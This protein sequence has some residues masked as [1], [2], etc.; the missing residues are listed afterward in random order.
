MR[1]KDR[2]SILFVSLIL[3]IGFSFTASAERIVFENNWGDAGFNL[4]IQDGAGVEIVFSVPELM[5]TDQ[6]V[7]GQTMQHVTIPGIYLPNDAGAPNLPGTGRYIALPQGATAQFEI[8]ETRT[9]IYKNL[10]IIPAAPIPKE[11]DTAPPVYEKDPAIY[12]VD[13]Y[14]PESPVQISDESEMRGVDVVILGVRPFQYNPVQKELVVYTDI[15]VRVTF[16]GGNGHFGEDRLRSRYWEPIL[17]QHLLNYESLPEVNFNRVPTGTDEDNVEYLIIVPD[18]PEFIAW[19]DTIKNWRKQQG[20]IT[21][22]TNLNEIG[23]NNYTMIESY[24]N[25]AYENW[26]IPPV[27]VLLLSDY[28]FSADDYGIDSPIWN[29]YCFS[30][31]LYADTG[32][33]QL[34]DFAIARIAAQNDGQLSTMLGKMLDYERTPPTAPNFYDE[35]LMAGGWQTERWFILCTEVIYGYFDLIHNKDPVREYAIYSGTPGTLWSTNQNT[36]MITNYFGPG[37]Y[38]YIPQTPEHLTNWT[39][40]AAGINA[41]IN[42]GCFILQHRDHGYEEGWGEPAYNIGDLNGLYNEMLPFVF[43]TNCCTGM[44][45]EPTEVFAEAFHRM[46]HGCLGIIA[47][48]E[49]SYSFVNDTYQW[50]VYDAMWPDFDPG[51]GTDETGSE[52]LRTAFANASGKHYLQV[53]S[54]PSN[55]GNKAHTYALFHH[56]GDAFMTLY[57]EVPQNLSVAHPPV[58]FPSASTVTV[59]ADSGAIVALTVDNEIIGITEATG[60]PLPIAIEPQ[61]PNTTIMVTVTLQN[62][63]R[64]MEE[65]DVITEEANYVVYYGMTLNDAAGNNNEL[66]DLGEDVL[67]SIAV[68]NLGTATAYNIEATITSEDPHVVI[69]DDVEIY[70]EIPSGGRVYTDD[71]YEVEATG[72]VPDLHEIEFTMTATNG[73]STWT[74]EFSII[75][76]APVVLYEDLL[77][78]DTIGG[79]GNNQLDPGETGDFTVTLFNDGSGDAGALD[80]VLSCEEPLITIENEAGSLNELISGESGDV[81][82]TGISAGVDITQGDTVQFI[83][84]ITGESGYTNTQ[85]F[86]TIIGDLRNNPMGPDTYG[87]WAYDMYDGDDGP[88]Y[89]WLEIAPALAGPGIDILIPAGQFTTVNLPFPFQ[90]YGLEYTMVSVGAHGW[91]EMGESESV[92]PINM[93][94]PHMVPPN[95]MIAGFSDD[96]APENGGQVAYYYDEENDR[97]IV[98]WHMVPHASAPSMFEKFQIV[99]LDPNVYQTLTGDGDVIV[100]YHTVMLSD[101]CSVGI[102]DQDGAIGMQYVWNDQYDAMCWPIEDGFAIRF[103]TVEPITPAESESSRMIPTE[104]A[105]GQNYPNP[106][107]PTTTLRFDLP[108]AAKVTLGVYDV[109]GRLVTTLIDGFHQAGSYEAIFDAAGLASGVYI[110]RMEAGDFIASGKMVML[111]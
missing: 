79:N 46:E 32:W 37:G 103:S 59:T 18:E 90:F 21:G 25:N 6:V 43:S 108:N 73:D 48:S 36:W 84:E 85:T 27:A 97:F 42:S 1:C 54:W 109:S 5:I 87:Y 44:F 93:P 51:Y 58:I 10:N 110:Y 14:Y 38:A 28:Q 61:L 40:N 98:E 81:T 102:E 96:L 67:L 69:H 92:Y 45:G 74:S 15:R 91:L 100:Y 105:L 66:L 13:S 57:S 17:Q 77:I 83:V 2:S 7:D 95:K 41:A 75:A 65:I 9:E 16:S 20:I 78:D 30:D 12:Q 39:G 52:N 8:V 11:T 107:N 60:G 63:F 89:D 34:P 19:G 99:L 29:N 35:P 22:V 76:H 49:V 3:I 72:D 101:N 106:F 71:G 62:Y 50:G 4:V 55:P 31:N 68:E 56:F 33:D 23:G 26:D 94:I 24:L 88:E 86:D 82:F 104:F 111:K 64:Y 53:S 47:A 80:F 70:A